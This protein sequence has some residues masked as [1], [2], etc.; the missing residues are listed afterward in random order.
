MSAPSVFTCCYAIK[1]NQ[2]PNCV[3]FTSHIFDVVLFWWYTGYALSN[4]TGN[5][6]AGTADLISLIFGLALI[7]MGIFSIIQMVTKNSSAVGRQ[8][9][10]AKL[11]LYLIIAIVVI[12]ILLFALVLLTV[13]AKAGD[14]V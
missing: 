5:S 8:A 6:K 14:K 4:R 7:A 11:R 2:D 13:N 10:Y 3:F 1:L 12:G 9:L